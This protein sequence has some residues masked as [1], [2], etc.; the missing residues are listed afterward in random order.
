MSAITARNHFETLCPEIVMK[1]LTEVENPWAMT[2]VSKFF[3]NY[4]QDSYLNLLRCSGLQ[5]RLYQV[6]GAGAED[7]DAKSWQKET[8]SQICREL[9]FLK[10]TP[11]KVGLKRMDLASYKEAENVI[12]CKSLVLLCQTLPDF[13]R[14]DIDLKNPEAL[15]EEAHLCCKH[16]RDPSVDLSQIRILDLTDTRVTRVPQSV[17]DQFPNLEELKM[18]RPS[19]LDRII[20]REDKEIRVTVITGLV[21]AALL[22]GG[23]IAQ[24]IV[25]GTPGYIGLACEIGLASGGVFAAMIGIA[26]VFMD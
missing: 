8:Y 3:E 18:N 12:Y 23:L 13:P 26:P 5:E 16:F 6:H 20:A 15:C 21:S 24:H 22:Y 7:T 19:D 9:R 4:F 1:I 2:I 25:E 14:R 11:E 17:L 10:L